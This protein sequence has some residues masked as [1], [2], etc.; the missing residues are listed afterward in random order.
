MPWGV[1]ELQIL[2]IQISKRAKVWSQLFEEKDECFF[3]PVGKYPSVV[4]SEQFTL[5]TYH[6]AVR[7]RARGGGRG[8]WCSETVF[9][10]VHLYQGCF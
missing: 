7:R 2:I 5:A 1:P 6:A 4:L 10:D 9:N 3:H 8:L